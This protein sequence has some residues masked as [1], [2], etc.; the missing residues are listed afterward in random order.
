M[1]TI[2]LFPGQ[3][4]QYPGMGKDLFDHFASV[5]ELFRCASDIAALDLRQILFEGD[6]E[7]LKQTNITQIGITLIN[8]S[9]ASVLREKGVEGQA[10]AGFSLGEYSA[11]W[12][13]GVLSTE[14]VFRAVVERGRLMDECCQQLNA[15]DDSGSEALPAGMA[16]VLG[17]S[18]DEVTAAL[19][20]LQDAGEQIYIANH[21]AAKQVVIAGSGAAI[22]TAGAAMDA[23]GAMKYVVLKVGGPFHTPLLKSAADNF[24]PFLQNEL[25]FAPP[26]IA[27]YS[28]VTGQ[29][30]GPEASDLAELAFRQIFSPVLWLN[31]EISLKAD[32]F[33]PAV[34]VGP[35]SVLSGLWK[36]FLRKEPCRPLGTLKQIEAFTAE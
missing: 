9:A 31:I 19:Q 34:E 17:L 33:G 23:A 5:R 30:I 10:T 35:G 16:A 28:N 14:A 20:P 12:Y 18:H 8:L 15:S 4:A 22:A 29:K 6:E 36:Q 26:Q 25:E 3:G 27:L 21:N 32:G 13:A 11:L 24:A 1:S 2:F 7:Q